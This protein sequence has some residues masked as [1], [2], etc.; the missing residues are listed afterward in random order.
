M[1]YENFI[2]LVKKRRSIRNFK[3][4]PIPDEHINK[5]IK[6]ARWSPSGFNMQ[7]WEFVVVKNQELKDS[8]AKYVQDHTKLIWEMEATRESW[9]GPKPE[10]PLPPMGFVNAPVFILLFGDTRTRAGL[11]MIHR[12]SDENWNRTFI[13]TLA[14]AFLYMHLAATTLDLASQWVSVV[15]QPVV[16]SQIKQFLGIPL[17]LQIYDMMALGYPA[18]APKPKMMRTEEEVIHYDYCGEDDFR[19][20]K[21]V[22]DLIYKVRN[23][24]SKP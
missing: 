11:P 15:T 16:R 6:A 7:P 12:Y 17:E 2:E 21:E 4:D 20:D 5:I 22:K 23:P 8:I 24:G 9:Q 14:S 1:E 18:M 19:S 10:G 3:S 13:S